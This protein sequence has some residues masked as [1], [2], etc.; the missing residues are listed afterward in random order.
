MRSDLS[1]LRKVP[2]L[3]GY[4]VWSVRKRGL[5]SLRGP[6]LW[7][8]P[9]D[10]PFV[11]TCYRN[12]LMVGRHPAPGER[13]TCGIYSWSSP[14]PEQTEIDNA[15]RGDRF[16]SHV[17]GV[18]ELIGKVI[19]H[20]RGYRSQTA[21]P[22]AVLANRFSNQVVDEYGLITIGDLREWNTPL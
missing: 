10:R 6:Q 21:R 17:W 16:G 2:R 7:P 20:A 14:P 19:V 9:S 11:A 15:M 4:R 13:C 18:V 22:V 3:F 5:Y 1:S 8:W 12:Y